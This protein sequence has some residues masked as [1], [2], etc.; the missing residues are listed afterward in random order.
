VGYKNEETAWLE[1][2]KPSLGEEARKLQEKVALGE[3]PTTIIEDKG[4]K[5]SKANPEEKDSNEKREW[6]VG[7]HCRSVFTQDQTEY[8]GELA[9][10][11]TDDNGRNYGTVVFVG[12]KN[13]ETA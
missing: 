1:E 8:E 12:Y 13:E 5:D 11:E 6:K 9:T 3:E 7:D 2:L 4:A 10:I